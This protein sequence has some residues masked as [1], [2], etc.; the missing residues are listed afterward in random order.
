MPRLIRITVLAGLASR[1]LIGSAAP[2][3]AECGGMTTPFPRFTEI[4]A[5]AERVVIGTVILDLADPNAL[6]GVSTSLAYY[7]VRVDE[8]LRGRAPETI[9]IRA[10]RT[11]V[12]VQ[13]SCPE[14]PLIY[15]NIG[16]VM[17]IAWGATMDGVD[18]RVNTA[19]WIVATGPMNNYREQHLTL[20]EARRGARALPDTAAIPPAES[21]PGAGSPWPLG[22]LFA[23]TL[24]AVAVRF[25]RRRIA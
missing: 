21:L 16:D 17:A 10:L 2:V 6:P 8:V 18:H 22:V 1:L 20:A 13:G 14:I 4:A 23:G 19:A 3:A 24:A 9:D 11:R 7:R 12:P 15:A 5:S 25:R